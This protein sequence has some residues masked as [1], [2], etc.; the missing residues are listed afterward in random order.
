MDLRRDAGQV[1]GSPPSIFSVMPVRNA[2]VIANSTAS[3]TSSGVP[4]VPVGL[5]SL[6]CGQLDGQ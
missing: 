5:D 6:M 2:L 4:M 3:A 1:S